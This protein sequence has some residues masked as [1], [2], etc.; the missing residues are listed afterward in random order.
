M[1]IYEMNI[2]EVIQRHDYISQ[3]DISN[4]VG[5][6]L[7]MVNLL[8]KKFTKV[9]IIKIERLNGKKVKYIL[10]PTGFTYLSK[11]TVDFVSRSYQAV[12]KIKLHMSNQIDKYFDEDEV[13]YIYGPDDEIL[14][15]LV[16]LLEEKKRKFERIE[17]IRDN[18]KFV[19]WAEMDSE[20]A[21][22]LF[23]EL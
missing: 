10:T 17:S 8:L 3:R 16:E 1:E 9:G 23:S 4:K 7:G 5:I 12:I 14:Q 18:E 6:S 22:Y 15:M 19:T 11:Q 13:V 21:R 2:L 20:N